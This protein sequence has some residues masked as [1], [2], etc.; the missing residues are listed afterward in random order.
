MSVSQRRALAMYLVTFSCTCASI[1]DKGYRE[2]P[3][4]WAGAPPMQQ[5]LGKE[6]GVWIPTNVQW[7][8]HCLLLQLWA[9]ALPWQAPKGPPESQVL[10]Q[11]VLSV[12]LK[13]NPGQVIP[14]VLTWP[15]RASSPYTLSPGAQN[16]IFIFEKVL[17]IHGRKKKIKTSSLFHSEHEFLNSP[18]Q[19]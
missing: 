15:A 12:L 9:A 6:G 11:P 18:S 10:S 5:A 3:R 13:T 17:H 8:I 14:T 7:N 16:F 2:S 19:K 4:R 1:W